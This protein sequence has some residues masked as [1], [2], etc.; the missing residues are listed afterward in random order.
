MAF[1]LDCLEVHNHAHPV[2]LLKALVNLAESFTGKPGT[3]KT[4]PAAFQL[5]VRDRAI[6]VTP[7]IR[8][9]AAPERF[10][11]TRKAHTDCAIHTAVGMRLPESDFL[12]HTGG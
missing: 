9:I 1:F 11:F 4:E 6:P 8:R 3:L 10:F 7:P 2:F 5:A 12:T